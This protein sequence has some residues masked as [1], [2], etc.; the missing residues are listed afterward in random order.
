ML[1][2]RFIRFWELSHFSFLSFSYFFSSRKRTRW[3]TCFL[4]T[5]IFLDWFRYTMGFLFCVPD[6]PVSDFLVR[7]PR[8]TKN[9]TPLSANQTPRLAS[10]KKWRMEFLTKEDWS[11]KQYTWKSQELFRSRALYF[12]SKGFTTVSRQKIARPCTNKSTMAT[13]VSAK[14]L[15]SRL[16][17]SVSKSAIQQTAV[18]Y[19]DFAWKLQIA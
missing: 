16:T 11:P 1:T 3:C 18:S 10:N 14:L 2:P 12:L 5:Y 7:C 13:T 4:G 15:I 19:V 17:A 6:S 9:P 8:M